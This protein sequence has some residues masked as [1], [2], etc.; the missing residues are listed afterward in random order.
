MIAVA[1]T[2]VSVS[3]LSTLRS[4]KLAA[5]P[6]VFCYRMGVDILSAGRERF[7]G[8]RARVGKLS[9]RAALKRNQVACSNLFSTFS[10]RFSTLKD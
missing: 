1:A 3:T 2:P 5:I 9:T 8:A 10:T 7:L 4:L 6:A